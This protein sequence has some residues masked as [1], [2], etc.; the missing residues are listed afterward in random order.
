MNNKITLMLKKLFDWTPRDVSAWETIRQKGWARFVVWYGAASAG[1][2][3]LAAGGVK[4]ASWAMLRLS[5]RPGLAGTAMATPATSLGAELL[6]AA[7]VCLAA[8]VV[9]SLLTWWVEEWLYRKY[10]AVQVK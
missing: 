2:L 4:L 7:V 5:E 8:G 1:V 10:Y 6:V 9:N 3:F